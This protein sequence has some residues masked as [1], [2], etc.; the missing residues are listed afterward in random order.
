MKRIRSSV[1]LLVLLAFFS[2]NAFAQT[3]EITGRVTSTASG[4]PLPDAE[5]GILGQ[6]S[7]VRTNERGEFHLRVPDGDVTIVARAIGYKRAA[8]RITAGSSVAPAFAL[9]KDVLEL[10]GVVVTGAATGVERRNAATAVSVVNSEALARVPAV[11]LESALQGKVIGAAI[12]MNNGAPGGGGQIQIRGASS[13]IGRIEPLIIVDGVAISNAVR[14]NRQ[15]NIT[16]SLNA[17]EENGTNRLADINPN[18]I[19]NVEVLKS[20]AASA[21][22][23]SQA[24][25]GVVIITTKRGS[26]GSPRFNFTQRVGTSSLI[27]KQ[28]SRHFQNLAQALDEIGSNPEGI[29]A[30]TAACTPTSCP[31]F[32]YQGELYGRKDPSYE[33]VMSLSGGVGS[34]RYYASG[35]DK[36]EAGIGLHTGARRQSLRANIDQNVGQRITID[37]NSNLLRSF[38][39]RGISNNDNSF[40]SPLYGFAYTPAIIDLRQKDALGQYVLNPFAGGGTLGGSNPFQTF[41]VM[42]NNEDV[43]RLI[44]AGK[45][46]WA[47]YSGGSNTLNF[48]V[49]GGADRYS[50]ENY[51]RAPQELQFQRAGTTEGGSFP[52]AIIQG[53]GT[54]RLTNV[55]GSAVWAFTPTWL[56][57]TTS[58][59]IQLQ[60]RAFNDYNIIGRGLG[61]QQDVAA[62]AQNISITDRLEK[63]RTQAAY[64]QEELLMFGERLYVSGAIRGERA[65]LNGDPRKTFYYPRASASYRFTPPVPGFGELKIR[66]S[67]GVSGNQPGYGDRFL[68]LTSY[69][70]IGGLPAYGLPGTIGNP[71]IK[72]ER[73]NEFEVG[74]D[75]AFFNERMRLEATRYNRKLTDLLVRPQLAPSTGIN[76]TVVNGGEMTTK[77]YEFGLTLVPVQSSGLNWTSRT[78]WY[79]SR[80]DITSFPPGVQPFTTGTAAGGFGNAY[81]RL[82]FA[83]GHTATTIW[84][85]KLVNGATVGNQPLADANPKYVMSFGNDLTYK[86]LNFNVLVDYRRGGTISNMTL[87]L[88]DE[89]ANTWDY[90]KP[91]PD[92]TVGATLG[93]YRYNSWGG[94]KN[95]AAYLV[96]GSF[97]KVREVNLSYD[98]PAGM[99]SRIRGAQ[100]GKISLSGRNLFIISGYNGFDPEVNNGGNFIARFVDL[101]PYPP[102]RSFWLSLDLGF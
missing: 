70:L 78:T 24:T 41:D 83:P 72:P 84:G 80:A 4:Q 76:G 16:G 17:A 52:G 34:T 48:S 49:Q 51:I 9:E 59:G 45:V 5:V 94:G 69:G 58:A 21:I 10:E 95:T 22:Y 62:G 47:A 13:L 88:F 18:D 20:A 71:A 29:A 63:S 2:T 97:T 98:L 99:V 46:N 14:S 74:L 82:R 68:A 55:T 12:N 19:A 87:N 75:G 79:Q 42:Q 7:G 11:S 39:Q 28:G 50:N 25:N 3:R 73:L 100:S 89:G 85:N 65:S 96:D 35:S 38:S 40:S 31:Y 27:R 91:S 43:Y 57:A 77:G 81:G 30:A 23:G 67:Y 90:D 64:G 56:S 93:A 101:A 1:V 102:S 37:L 15:Q 32:D 36:Q 33:S 6:T 8:Q 60:D 61:P 86:S 44:F 26:E 54:E 92:P 66:T 53:N